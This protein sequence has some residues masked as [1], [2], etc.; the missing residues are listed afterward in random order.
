MNR[1][2]TR[3]MKTNRM[4]KIKKMNKM[5]KNNLLLTINKRLMSRYKLLNKK[6]HNF[7]NNFKNKESLC[8]ELIINESNILQDLNKLISQ[9]ILF[10]I[11]MESTLK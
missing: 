7:K 6:I 8:Q 4:N 11:K 2:M 1:L 5:S 10:R 3:M 9:N